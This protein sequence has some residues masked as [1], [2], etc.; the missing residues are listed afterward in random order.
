MEK[1]TLVLEEGLKISDKLINFSII[2]GDVLKCQK[3]ISIILN[4]PYT[5]TLSV[6]TL[7]TRLS[8]V[9]KYWTRF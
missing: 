7:P 1:V 5:L 2:L 6:N 9:R 8:L 4:I 3:Y